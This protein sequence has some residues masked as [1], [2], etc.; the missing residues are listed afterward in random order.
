MGFLKIKTKPQKIDIVLMILLPVVAATLTLIFKTNFLIST[1]LFFGLPSLYLSL[2][3]LEIVPRSLIFTALFSIPLAI[4]IDYLAVMDKS[5]SVP[6]SLFSSRFLGVIPI[7]DFIWGFL[8]VFF[9]VM[10]YEYFLDF[11]KGEDRLAKNIKYFTVILLSLLILFFLFL[12]ISPQLLHI[13]YFYLKAGI[14]L[15]LLPLVTFLSFF[16][17]F[18]TKYLK[19]GI[20]FLGLSLLFELVGLQTNQWTFPGH[21]FISFIEIFGLRIPVEEFLFWIVLGVPW[22]LSYYEFFAD[23]KR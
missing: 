17:K 12:F 16:P 19:I 11:G 10:F 20:Y 7:E 1:L 13:E 2:R 8:Y 4:I 9:I 3:K 18:W 14:I 21:N 5:W 23:D 22:I 15:A 6:T